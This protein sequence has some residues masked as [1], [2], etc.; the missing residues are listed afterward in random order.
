MCHSLEVRVPLLDHKLVE[1]VA[2]I[3]ARYKLKGWE[4]KHILI[5][6]LNGSLPKAILGRRKQGFSVPLHNWL[7]GPLRELI[8]TYLAEPATRGLGLF[9][10][11]TVA[12][13]LGEHE[14]GLRNHESRI[15]ALLMFVLWHELYM[16]R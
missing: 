8:H 5:R 10:P 9:N 3:P 7:R 14:Q 12:T 16:R 1:F 15:W 13:I 4:K 2:T 6:A 11:K